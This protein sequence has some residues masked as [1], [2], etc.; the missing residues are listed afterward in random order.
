M[1]DRNSFQDTFQISH[2]HVGESWHCPLYLPA[3]GTRQS[4]RRESPRTRSRGWMEAGAGRQ[5]VRGTGRGE[6]ERDGEGYPSSVHVQTSAIAAR[7][8]EVPPA[9]QFCCGAV[10]LLCA[11]SLSVFSL[12]PLHRKLP[13]ACLVRLRRG[14]EVSKRLA[15][16]RIKSPKPRPTS[17]W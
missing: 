1:S 11:R 7:V 13:L 15:R 12:S 8:T 14:P 10:P 9:R 6:R 3:P 16:P 5:T 4:R 2:P 17:C